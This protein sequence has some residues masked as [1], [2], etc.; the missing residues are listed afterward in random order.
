MEWLTPFV[1]GAL[2]AIVG[3]VVVWFI[4]SKLTKIYP[5]KPFKVDRS[6]LSGKWNGKHLSC[7]EG[8][9]IISNHIHELKI[10]PNGRI[11]GHYEELSADPPHLLDTEGRIEPNSIILFNKSRFSHEVSLTFLFNI[12]NTNRMMGFHLGYDF[13]RKPF[14]SL[15]V[16]TREKLTDKEFLILVKN[17]EDILL[18]KIDPLIK[19]TE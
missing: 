9:I 1:I 5:E 11:E 8:R 16:L 3:G 15:I 7:R 18:N 14:V 12:V 6:I 19:L 13:D 17:Y 2:S 4:T 10:A